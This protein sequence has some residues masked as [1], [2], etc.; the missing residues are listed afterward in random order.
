MATKKTKA[1]TE[2]SKLDVQLGVRVSSNDAERIKALAERFPM[3]SGNGIA[4][5]AIQIGLDA[6]EGQPT[7]LLGEKPRR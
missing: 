5:R 4:R 1:E 7:L 6:I 2:R 3:L